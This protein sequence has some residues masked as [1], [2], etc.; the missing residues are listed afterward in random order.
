MNISKKIASIFF[1]PTCIASVS[2]PMCVSCSKKPI[3]KYY[4][5]GGFKDWL[6]LYR[7]Y[8][9]SIKKSEL[10]QFYFDKIKEDPTILINDLCWKYI[11]A[12]GPGFDGITKFDIKIYDIDSINHTMSFTYDIIIPSASWYQE[13]VCK[14]VNFKYYVDFDASSELFPSFDIDWDIDNPNGSWIYNTHW[15]YQLYGTTAAW[16]LVIDGGFATSESSTTTIQHFLSNMMNVYTATS[17][18][19]LSKATIIED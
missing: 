1:I 5:K 4:F 2:L 12:F 7:P 19:Y 10:T 11:Y 16:A 6:P 3:A 8:D 13:Y 15:E 14:V 18:N 17:S 9:G